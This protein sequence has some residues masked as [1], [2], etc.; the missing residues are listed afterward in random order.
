MIFNYQCI[1]VLR[2]F[3]TERTL[4]VGPE[5]KG[6]HQFGHVMQ[7]ADFKYGTGMETKEQ[8]EEINY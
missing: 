1:A 4:C 5:L 3:M 2:S 7:S 8:N 6:S